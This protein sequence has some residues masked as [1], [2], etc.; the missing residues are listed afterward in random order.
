M[1]YYIL[2]FRRF[3]YF[4]NSN[5]LLNY[6]IKIPLYRQLPKFGLS[7]FAVAHFT[8]IYISKA[9]TGLFEFFR[10]AFNI[11]QSSSLQINLKFSC[12]VNSVSVQTL[13]KDVIHIKHN[14][15][16]ITK[17]ERKKNRDVIEIL[18]GVTETVTTYRMPNTGNRGCLPFT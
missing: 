7:I 2:K 1:R 6:L 15:D 17:K 10:R 4:A 11:L 16:A 5:Y 3:L 14:A 8:A 9:L 13:F 18:I 12:E